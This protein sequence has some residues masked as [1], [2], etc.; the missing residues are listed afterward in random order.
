MLIQSPIIVWKKT[1]VNIYLSFPFLQSA[2]KKVLIRKFML[3]SSFLPST[4]FFVYK[5]YTKMNDKF[6]R[7]DTSNLLHGMCF[8]DKRFFF[9]S[10]S[11][12]TC[13]VGMQSSIYYIDLGTHS[14]KILWMG[15]G[16]LAP[17]L[18]QSRANILH[19]HQL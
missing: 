2:I 8:R 6:K 15:R 11:R 14:N 16:Q 10:L 18:F 7:A 13:Y 19:K 3:F 12:P 5:R 1:K 9:K 4:F 17:F